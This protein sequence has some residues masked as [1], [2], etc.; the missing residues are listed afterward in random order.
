M[1]EFDYG[2]TTEMDRRP[3]LSQEFYGVAFSTEERPFFVS[4]C[5][6]IYDI[7]P[8]DETEIVCRCK[9]HYGVTLTE[10]HLR[11]PL[12]KVLDFLSEN[13]R[14]AGLDESPRRS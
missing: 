2:S 10:K 13:R 8:G 6:S 7:S 4:D 5:A 12:W 1:P 14:I 3:I 9:S 11:M